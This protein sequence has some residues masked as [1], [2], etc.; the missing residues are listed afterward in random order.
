MSDSTRQLKLTTVFSGTDCAVL[1]VSGE[2]DVRTE[3][4]FL[5][6]A[7]TV[8]EDGHRFLVLDMTA[9][10]FCDSRG[11][12]CLLAMEWLCRQLDGHLLL[13]SPGARLL[14]LLMIMKVEELFSCYPTV[15]HALSAVPDAYRP[16]WPPTHTATREHPPT[17]GPESAPP[18]TGPKPGGPA[19]RPRGGMGRL[20]RDGDT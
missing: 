19:S 13:A 10:R 1:R 18:A 2:L 4:Q 6:Y 14:H 8:I 7:G 16:T 5:S 17:G 9:L 15:G 11:L 12:N 20:R 3:K